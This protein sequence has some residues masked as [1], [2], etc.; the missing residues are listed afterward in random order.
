VLAREG[1]GTPPAQAQLGD[2]SPEPSP[3]SY[4]S[5]AGSIDDDEIEAL[6]PQQQRQRE[7]PLR[8][9]S[10]TELEQ[11]SKQEDQSSLQGTVPVPAQQQA[12][13]RPLR[14]GGSASSSSTAAA[15]AVQTES[16]PRQP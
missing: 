6:Q 13:F 4:Y 14:I 2:T 8:L 11:E 1:A 16:A 15:D 9:Q 10:I 3:A 5:D 7:Q 12:T